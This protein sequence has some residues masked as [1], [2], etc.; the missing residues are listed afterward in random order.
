MEVITWGQDSP[1]VPAMELPKSKKVRNSSHSIC[2][3]REGSWDSGM[4]RPGAICWC[5]EG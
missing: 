2:R 4:E 3:G 5:L 1:G